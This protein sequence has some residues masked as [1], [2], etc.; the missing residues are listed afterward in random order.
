MSALAWCSRIGALLCALSPTGCM[1]FDDGTAGEIELGTHV[2]D[3][4]QEVIYQVLVDRF[5]DGDA[6]NNYR[7]DLSAQGKYHGGDWRGLWEKLDYLEELGVTTIWISPSVKN[8]DT[9]AGFDGYHGY[10][11]QDPYTAN[12][13]FGDIA[14]LRRLVSGAHER[15]MKVILDIVT[16]HMGQIFYYD[17]NRNGEP[18]DR[19]AGNGGGTGKDGT[20]LSPVT[21][22]NEY[23]PD[24]DARGI[25]SFTSLGEAGPAPIIFNYDPA[26]NHVPPPGIFGYAEVYNR[27]GRTLNYDD[28]VQL[29]KGDFP[30]GLKDID[31]SRCDVKEAMVDAYARWVELTDLD[32]FRIDTVKHVEREFWRFFTQRIRQRLAQKGKTNFFMFGEAFDG[33]DELIGS[34]TKTDPPPQADLAAE[35]ECARQSGGPEITGDQLDSVFYFSQY[36]RIQ[37]VF[38]GLL[39]PSDPKEGSTQKLQEIWSAR[40]TNHGTQLVKD[41]IG[42]KPVDMVVNFLD[43]HDVARFLSPLRYPDADRKLPAEEFDALRQAILKNA[44]LF[45]LTEQG[46]PCIY[47]GTEQNFE[48]G[49]DPA[50]REDMWESGYDTTN[51]TFQWIKRLTKIRRSYKA[52]MIGGQN[53]VWATDRTG[54]N[55]EDAG[56]F[57]FERTG[58]DATNSYALVVINTNKKNP[59]SPQYNGT[60]ML[61]SIPANTVLVDV[62]S[63]DKATYTVDA[64]SRLS[65][66]LPPL[67]GAL[68]VPQDQVIP[69]L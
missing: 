48:G 9:D 8:V 12:P 20:P 62:L 64:D 44:L 43:N 54:D 22:I 6:G 47:Y 29:L 14:S 19:V 49:N 55:D 15:G 63:A 52:L 23:D 46:V 16:N 65:I 27:K 61:V 60:P 30:G 69:N 67:S 50:N 1:Q 58:G 33:R 68:L 4:R 57:A 11:T 36:F 35:N 42:Q 51:S 56:V 32:G 18:D 2:A 5:A 3:W 37:N 25:Q 59:G 31:T 10:W 41:G 21:H 26:S 7:V 66:S 38:Q 45:L 28:P 17:I 53:V 34:F 40:P 39:Y 13:H 24:F